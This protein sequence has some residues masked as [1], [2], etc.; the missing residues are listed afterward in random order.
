LK[1]KEQQPLL[2]AGAT[3]AEQT[4]QVDVTDIEPAPQGAGVAV[5]PGAPTKQRVLRAMH[6]HDIYL[7]VWYE[8][9]L[10]GVVILLL[11]GWS[12]FRCIESMPPDM[13][14]YV[15]AVRAHR[16][17]GG[18]DLWA[19]AVLVPGPA[20]AELRHC[21]SRPRPKFLSRM[22]FSEYEICFCKAG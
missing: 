9:G 3:A 20:G 1:I 8:L 10:V 21:R 12:I 7:Q 11:L 18:D 4:M 15:L 16:H 13:Q 19:L 5:A 14:P 6:P 17:H 2:G 22:F